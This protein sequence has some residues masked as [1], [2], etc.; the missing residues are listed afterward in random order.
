[1]RGY[2]EQYEPQ[3]SEHAHSEYYKLCDNLQPH[4]TKILSNFLPEAFRIADDLQKVQDAHYQI[5]SS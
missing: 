2:D 3:G 5:F 4:N 1:M